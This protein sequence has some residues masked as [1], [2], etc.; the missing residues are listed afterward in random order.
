[1]GKAIDILTEIGLDNIQA[2]EKVLNRKLI[3]GLK[4]YDKETYDRYAIIYGDFENIDDRVGVV[5]F[6]FEGINSF[7]L[8]TRLRDQGAA[9]TRR[10][11]FCAH[12]YVWRLMGIDE[13]TRKTLVNCNDWNTP[14]MIRISF[15]VYNTEEEVDQFLEILDELLPIT[16]ATQDEYEYGVIDSDY[17]TSYA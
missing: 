15:G 4:K 1:M 6:N 7:T 2:H 5:T 17:S 8:A 14:G 16:A 13:E 10:G 12:T 3:D 11:A 9:A